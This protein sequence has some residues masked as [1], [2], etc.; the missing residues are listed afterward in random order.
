MADTST[1]HSSGTTAP[2]II[3]PETLPVIRHAG[4]PVVTTALLAKL[5][6]TVD[7]NLIKNF[8][9]N[10]ARFEEGKHYHRL[11]GEELRALKHCMT[12]SHSVDIPPQAR[13]LLLW[14]ERGAARHAKMLDTDA[15]WDVFEKLE[16]CYFGGEEAE[17]L[18][19]TAEV[20]RQV[21]FEGR[22]IRV[23]MRDGQPWFAA[24]HVASALRLRSSDRITR[25]A[26]ATEIFSTLRGRQRIN[27]MSPAATLRA[28]DYAECALGER[29]RIWGKALLAEL[30]A[31]AVP[32]TVVQ[33]REVPHPLTAPTQF[34]CCG[35]SEYLLN[36]RA[37]VR[38]SD[39]LESTSCILAE[40]DG[41]LLDIASESQKIGVSQVYLLKRAVAE[42]KAIVDSVIT[43]LNQQAA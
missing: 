40:V 11:E 25:S 15:A 17:S 4:K 23:L 28:G 14:T 2:E 16:D 33:R 22:R 31:E 10:A 18:P 7:N 36:V 21:A 26:L 19:Q 12:N 41:A 38:A 3:S 1:A 9:R 20:W 35:V 39:A 32:P 24:A 5:Y 8:Q 42:A 29:W 30:G 34:E 6:G 13:N 37:G 43:G 27:F